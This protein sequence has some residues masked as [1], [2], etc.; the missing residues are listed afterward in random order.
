ME[1]EINEKESEEGEWRA[2]GGSEK[3]LANTI[4][5]QP[6]ELESD[7]IGITYRPFTR[8]DSFFFSSRYS[9]RF[10][11]HCP[12]VSDECGWQGRLQSLEERMGLTG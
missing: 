5:E 8:K 6:F 1:E 11:I 3:E 2:R 12:V 7:R 4:A 10:I 9:Y